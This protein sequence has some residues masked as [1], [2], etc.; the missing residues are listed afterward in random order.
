MPDTLPQ[1]STD[2]IGAFVELSRQGKIRAA[3]E[4]L[5][6]TEQGLRN[7]LLALEQR[8][9]VEL[10]RKSRGPRRSTVLTDQGR[11]FLPH[12]VAFLE[13]AQELFRTFDVKTGV[14][15]LRV[16]SSQYLIR[17]LVID[18]L[19]EFRRAAPDI[20][21][22]ISTMNELDV[23]EALRND[24]EV[25]MGVVAPYEPSPDFDY[26]E[27]FAMDWSLLTP[28]RHPLLAK[29]KVRLQDL[30]SQPLIL[31]ERGST[32]R[33]HVLDAFHEQ[34]LSPRV[35]LETTGTETI[36]SMVEAG[37][38]ISIVPLLPSGAVTRGRRVEVRALEA[39][40]RPI[41]SGVLLR[42][43][44]RLSAASARLFDFIRSHA[45]RQTC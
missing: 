5:G 6:I 28:P 16:A 33:Q 30:T 39:S 43:G 14:Q 44:E 4:V 21:V 42:R 8:L 24:P 40:I 7:R 10:Y 35:A 41:H 3:A 36:V 31:Y 23:E 15:E 19:K 34:G 11:R 1:L 26:H 27:L 38:G 20:H 37:L 29:R 18:V 17:Y 45:A 13:R 9:G 2:Q 32:G 12:A 25:A 22:R